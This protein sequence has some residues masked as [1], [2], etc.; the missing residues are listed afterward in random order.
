MSTVVA[1]ADKQKVLQFGNES[2]LTGSVLTV[3][4]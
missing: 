2:L 1:V 4:I 3:E